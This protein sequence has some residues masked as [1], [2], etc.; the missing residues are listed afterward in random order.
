[1][2]RSTA[3]VNHNAALLNE[4]IHILL[5]FTI[6]VVASPD[7][8]DAEI[9]VT[10]VEYVNVHGYATNKEIV[11]QLQKLLIPSKQGWVTRSLNLTVEII[12]SHPR[13]GYQTPAVENT[14]KGADKI[15]SLVT[16]LYG[17]YT[18][19]LNRTQTISVAFAN[20]P[21]RTVEFQAYQVEMDLAWFEAHSGY[22]RAGSTTRRLVT[23]PGM[24]PLG[25]RLSPFQAYGTDESE[26]IEGVR[27]EESAKKRPAKRCRKGTTQEQRNVA[28]LCSQLT[29]DFEKDAF[30]KDALMFALA[31]SG[32]VGSPDVRTE[33]DKATVSK[34]KAAISSMVLGF[35][36]EE[37]RWC[38]IDRSLNLPQTRGPKKTS[39]P[40]QMQDAFKCRVREMRAFVLPM[41][42]ESL[43]AVLESQDE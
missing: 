35:D 11:E 24:L 18:N 42:V 32:F 17:N 26:A 9:I 29:K 41:V 31:A 5:F 16:Y 15:D 3:I 25:L 30:Q 1:M 21:F 12:G 38:E 19:W 23:G 8:S 34:K 36:A 6:L 2:E 27:E 13:S 37:Y 43:Q 39:M 28:H 7:A 20:L 10:V 22:L 33:E 14:A 40:P 4:G